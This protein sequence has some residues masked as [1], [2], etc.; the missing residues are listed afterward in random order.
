[1]RKIESLKVNEDLYEVIAVTPINVFTKRY[2]DQPDKL[3][4]GMLGLWVNHIGGERVVRRD[5]SLLILK[6]VEEAQVIEDN[7]K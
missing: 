2:K 1:M 7:I 6:L 5:N 4:E 3:H